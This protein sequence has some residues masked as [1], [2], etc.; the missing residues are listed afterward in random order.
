MFASCTGLTGSEAPDANI[1]T[2]HRAVGVLLHCAACYA[3]QGCRRSAQ[4]PLVFSGVGHGDETSQ[5]SAGVLLLVQLSL[6]GCRGDAA[7]E[8]G[9]PVQSVPCRRRDS[10]LR[11]LVAR[12]HTAM[13]LCL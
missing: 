9:K 1:I 12:H 8:F 4:R 3:L 7:A 6:C 5:A 13:H 10:R 2:S 11:L